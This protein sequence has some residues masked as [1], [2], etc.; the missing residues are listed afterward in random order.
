MG[1]SRYNPLNKY[2]QVGKAIERYGDYPRKPEGIQ[3]GP[4]YIPKI[5]PAVII[6]KT[7]V[8]KE[9]RTRTES[10]APNVKRKKKRGYDI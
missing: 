6:E 8:D 5:N 10:N 4:P 2:M 9:G 7:I 1:I 3:K